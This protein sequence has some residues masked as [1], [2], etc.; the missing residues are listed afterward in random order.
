MKMIKKFEAF[1]GEE[2][3]NVRGWKDDLL[4]MCDYFTELEDLNEIETID[5]QAGYRES[6]GS[7][8]YC[9]FFDTNKEEI[10]GRTDMIDHKILVNS[11]ILLRAMFKI[12]Y[13]N[14]NY[15]PFKTSGA[16]AYFAEN[17]ESFLKIMGKLNLIKTRMSEK[18]NIGI[19]METD[20]IYI[21]FLEK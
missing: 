4:T 8:S 2:E 11:K 3:G 1:E 9:C 17:A 19:S 20:W 13:K 16:T 7:I 15:S 6:S 18:Y 12:R 21:N 14:N 5:Y 10:L